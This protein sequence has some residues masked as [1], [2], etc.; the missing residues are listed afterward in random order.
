[1]QIVPLSRGTIC[2]HSGT[3]SWQK[4]QE[5]LRDSVAVL[6]TDR[7]KFSKVGS[8]V[9][10]YSQLSSELTFENFDSSTQRGAARQCLKLVS[11][12]QQTSA[13]EWFISVF[14]HSQQSA[15]AQRELTLVNYQRCRVGVAGEYGVATISR[16]LKNICLFAEYRSLLQG[17]F[18]KETYIF[19]HPTNRSHPIE[20]YSEFQNNTEE[21]SQ[22][23]ENAKRADT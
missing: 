15:C 19:K 9:I 8:A 23:R 14:R 2:I 22:E 7:Q 12:S 20:F 5:G 16:M 18:A 21:F 11:N 13:L 1:M 10:F 17:S 3:L 6:K 4:C